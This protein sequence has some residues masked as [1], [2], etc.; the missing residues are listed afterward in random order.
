MGRR[1]AAV[2]MAWVPVLVAA[3]FVLP[4]YAV[5]ELGVWSFSEPR[6]HLRWDE[7]SGADAP[8]AAAQP[9]GLPMLGLQLGVGLVLVA[10][11]VA[12]PRVLR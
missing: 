4:L 10:L 1:A 6:S 5:G 8:V 12:W 2:A 7:A 11:L 3:L 9:G